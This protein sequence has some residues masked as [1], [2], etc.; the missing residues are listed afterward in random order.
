MSKRPNPILD[1]FRKKQKSNDFVTENEVDDPSIPT[2]SSTLSNSG[3][4]GNKIKY[5]YQK[6][7]EK[8][9]DW[10][11]L[12]EEKGGAFCKVCEKFQSHN[13][14]ALQKS[15][16]VFIITPFTNFRKAAGK[17]GKLLKH[18]TSENHT[19]AVALN[20]I[21]LLGKSKPIYT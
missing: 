10:L 7:W 21:F 14:G 5:S 1:M 16:G 3:Y 9:Y 18:A 2:T 11:Y 8:M 12:N 6:N 17:T 20:K 15:Q 4:Q 19:K 13:Q